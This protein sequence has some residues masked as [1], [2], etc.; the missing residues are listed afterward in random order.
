M[1]GY[2]SHLFLKLTFPSF[3]VF[4]LF[5]FL[6]KKKLCISNIHLSEASKTVAYS[7]CGAERG[8]DSSAELS[9]LKAEVSEDTF[10]MQLKE[11][12]NENASCSNG[13]K[14]QSSNGEH[15]ARL[16]S[17]HRKKGTKPKVH[18]NGSSCTSELAVN[19]GKEKN[20]MSDKE[21]DS[22]AELANGIETLTLK[23]SADEDT[24]R[25]HVSEDCSSPAVCSVLDSRGEC[26]KM[27]GITSNGHENEGEV[28]ESTSKNTGAVSRS[29]GSDKPRESEAID[30]VPTSSSTDSTLDQN[31][32]LQSTEVQIAGSPLIS[33]CDSEGS[34]DSG[35]GGSEFQFGV[36]TPLHSTVPAIPLV[37]Y[38]FEI[39]QELCGLLIGRNGRHVNFIKE[40]TNAN[41]LIKRHPF[42]TQLK[43][44]A[45]SG[46]EEEVNA[47]LSLIRKRFPVDLYPNV[48]M[49]QINVMPSPFQIS[50][51]LRLSL[52]EGVTFDAALSATVSAGH[53]FL[54]QPT[55]PTYHN[56]SWLLTK[57][58]SIYEG[59]ETPKLIT[60][61]KGYI[62]VARVMDGWYRAE[63]NQ[64]DDVTL[65][66]NIKF[67]DF[68]GYSTVPGDSLRQIRT[69]C[70][71]VPFQASECYLGS[72]KFPDGEEQWSQEATATFEELAQ[73][74]I[75]QGY[76]VG[77]A[78]DG[79]PY[80]HLFRIQGVS[81]VFI[82]RELVNR[83][84]AQWISHQ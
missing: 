57:M 46:T 25:Q 42:Y 10:K 78:E 80:V 74:Q 50:D 39:P 27:N 40:K 38:E 9:G 26:S 31:S 2:T 70:M 20:G 59:K 6:R 30:I 22:G 60:L 52:P 14:N 41:I 5:W 13:E 72:V 11:T 75:L 84:L 12:T 66:C 21:H 15:N 77:Y 32:I 29:M 71:H 1:A 45:V 69:D 37:L 33:Y 35:K 4:G 65:Q 53:F 67:L 73:G 55:H 49:L 48:T 34:N 68:G 36:D 58:N 54:Q 16:K 62:C 64:I 79:I 61:S 81:H 3:I 28:L 56:L 63:I 82:N 17:K 51:I 44:C 83:G 24:S 43:I 7:E 23:S 47:A 18:E 76:I 19:N 8:F